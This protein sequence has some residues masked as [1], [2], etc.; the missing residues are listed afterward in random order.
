MRIFAV[1]V[2]YKKKLEESQTFISLVGSCREISKSKSVLFLLIYDNSPQRQDLFPDVPFNYE[3]VHDPQNNGLSAAYNYALGKAASMD[4]PW[5]LLLDHDSNL[6]CDYIASIERAVG[7]HSSNESIVSF[8]PKVVCNGAVVSPSR[9]ILGVQF[10][11]VN[12]GHTGISDF[13]MTAIN[14]GA[15]VKVPFLEQIKGFSDLFKL[16]FLD[17]WLFNEIYLNN[18]RVYVFNSIIQHDLSVNNIN[19]DMSTSRY[20]NILASEKLF[21]FKYKTAGQKILYLIKLFIRFIKFILISENKKFAYIVLRHLCVS[22]GGVISS[23]R[24]KARH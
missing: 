4:Y 17:H 16:D 13:H 14:S 9:V 10:L 11:P 6:P 1:L 5:L 15:L 18:K 8:V 19:A 20:I 23:Y 12:I 21:Y 7:R 22:T 24:N 3:Y 2:I